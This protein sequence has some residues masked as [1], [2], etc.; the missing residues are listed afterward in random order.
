METGM[1]IRDMKTARM[2]TA[3]GSAGRVGRGF[4]LIE[5]LVGIAIVAL[6]IGIQLPA[7]AKAR[8]A[9]YRTR[10]LANAR[11]VGSGFELYT[12]DHD[13][14]YPFVAPGDDPMGDPGMQFVSVDW[15]PEETIIA[16]ND[17]FRLGWAWPSP[18]SR[19]LPWEENYQT[20]VS[21]GMDTGLPEA[22]GLSDDED[23]RPEDDISWRFS[24]SF[25]GDPALWG[26]TPPAETQGLF[27][28]VRLYEVVF[29]SKKV[30]LWDTHLAFLPTEPELREGHWDA[31]TPMAFPA[32]HAEARNPLDAAEGVPNP[33]RGDSDDR[34]HNTPD[35][36]RGTDY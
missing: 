24:H 10:A 7:L 31:A 12:T 36:V 3:R 21:P 27:R 19:V 20:W 29:P 9:G 1:A 8:V 15:Y 11:T 30:L 25:L 18:M 28:P 16:T 22:R 17:L 2:K 26:E 32:G 14:T 6:L 23:R 35:G 5:V 34:L 13:D 4:T 33:L